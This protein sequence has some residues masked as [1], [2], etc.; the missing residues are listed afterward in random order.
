LLGPRDLIIL[1]GSFPMLSC[2]HGREEL[3]SEMRGA[4]IFT[5]PETGHLRGHLFMSKGFWC[6]GRAIVTGRFGR[7]RN[8]FAALCLVQSN[9]RI[10]DPSATS[11]SGAPL[12]GDSVRCFSISLFSSSNLFLANYIIL[13]M[14]FRVYMLENLIRSICVPICK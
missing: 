4:L 2:S 8:D 1:S 11:T 7:L 13:A 12:L 9:Y 5:H 6:E 10:D 14:P 3:H